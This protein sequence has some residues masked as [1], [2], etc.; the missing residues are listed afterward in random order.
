MYNNYGNVKIITSNGCFVTRIDINQERLGYGGFFN[1][2]N[3]RIYGQIE[4]YSKKEVDYNVPFSICIIDILNH[5]N[6]C[7]NDIWL[8]DNT[9]TF[10]NNIY[11]YKSSYIARDV[12]KNN[13]IKEIYNIIFLKRH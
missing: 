2:N 6:V 7:I 10:E 13:G 12:C 4:I 3:I 5:Y 1:T 9:I 11:I 8:T